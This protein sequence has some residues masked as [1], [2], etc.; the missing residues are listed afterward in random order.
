MP[1]SNSARHRFNRPHSSTTPK[2]TSWKEASSWY[3]SIVGE[4]GHEY[5]QELIFPKLLEQGK[6]TDTSSILDLG[7][8]QGVLSRI[9]PK[10]ALYTGID[11]AKPLIESAL[12]YSNR[13]PN[14][15]FLHHDLTKSPWPL[16]KEQE[17]SFS[18]IISI[19]AL[20]NMKDPGRVLIEASRFL[21]KE[22]KIILV[23]NHPCFRIPRKSRWGFDEATK[24]QT[25]ELFSYMTPQEIPIVT[26][27]GKIA[28]GLTSDTTWS[29]H[30]SL[31][32]W[33][34]MIYEAQLIIEK[35][36]EWISPKTSTGKNARSENRA[37]KEFPL[38]LA[39]TLQKRP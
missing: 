6:F 34:R 2:D 15:S 13:I 24:T 38:F 5:H 25:R 33:S 29:F 1:D 18:H 28:S 19:L 23:L 16:K 30:H 11:F 12:R 22:G 20:Q 7:S 27:P 36:D 26:H 39:Y 4:K 32:D 35:M 21:H 17:G 37:R 10:K 3:N 14:R 31:S 9:L 8:G